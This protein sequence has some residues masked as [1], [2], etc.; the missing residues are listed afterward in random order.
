MTILRKILPFLILLGCCTQLEARHIIGG[1]ITYVCRG[2]AYDFT[3]RIYRDCAGNGACFDAQLN[4]ESASEAHVT[5]FD[6]TT[7]IGVAYL[8]PPT[9]RRIQPNLSNPCL[10]AP[11]NVCVEEG[12]YTFSAD[13][14]NTN[15]SLTLAYQRCCRNVTI[16][17]IIAPRDVGATYLAELFPVTQDSCNSSPTFNDFPPIVICQGEDVN[18][19]HSATD[20]E[21]DSLVYSFCTPFNGGGNN[22]M[23]GP[24][25][26]EAPNGVTPNPETPPP[27]DP[28]RFVAGYTVESPLNIFSDR[29]QADIT[30]DEE[31]GLISGFPGSTGQYVVGVCVRAYENGVLMNEVRRDFQFNVAAC[32]NGLVSDVQETELRDKNGDPLYYIRICGE[33]DIINEST[34][35]R[36]I[37]DQFWSFDLPGGQKTTSSKW[38][39]DDLV[40]PGAGLYDGLLVL[41]PGFENCTDTAL[42][43]VEVFPEVVADFE[44]EYDTCQAGPVNFTNLSYSDAGPNA[45]KELEWQLDTFGTSARTNVFLQFDEPGRYDVTLTAKDTNECTESITKEVPYFPIPRILVI[46]P[47]AKIGCIPASITFQNLSNPIN[48]DYDIIWN[49]GDGIMGEGVSP[50]HVYEEV[51]TFSLTL[52]VT[53]PFG[54][55]IDTAFGDLITTLPSPIADFSAD[56]SEVSRLNPIV[57]FMDESVDAIR[58]NWL[59]DGFG[60]SFEENPVYT[61]RE[62]GR[63]QVRLIVTADNGCTDTTYSEILVVPDIAY[64][65]PNAFTPNGDGN[66]DTFFGVGNAEEAEVF[67]LTIWNRWGELIFE[68]NDADEGWNGQKFNTGKIV[69]NGVYVVTVSYVNYEDVV[70]N[71]QGFVTVL[72]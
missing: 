58:W 28:V 51:G 12:V 27:Y 3:M 63:K 35:R 17:N 55:Q 34:E 24:A 6:G 13:L 59:F 43:Q 72:R 25:V 66:N 31:T 50:T 64:K 60:L 22:F 45:L 36:F 21:G 65:L 52:S 56:A 18:F 38:D 23:G 49:F 71:L 1:E 37:E 53:S 26:T 14:P 4:C 20:P 8:N 46:A 16:N 9:V 10:I 11:P 61:F 29:D 7:V 70:T 68:T 54:C 19:D 2:G 32:R 67:Q 5:F 69:P 33:G 57:T 48:E 15:N 39:P 42:V 44:F 41:N 47:S 30:I 62:S 40:F